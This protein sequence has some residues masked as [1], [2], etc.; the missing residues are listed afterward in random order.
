MSKKIICGIILSILIVIIGLTFGISSIVKFVRM[1]AIIAD[2]KNDV[3]KENYYLKIDATYKGKTSTTET[4]YRDG[5]GKL[6]AENGL[7]TWTDGEKAY[8]VDESL[9]QVEELDYEKDLQLLVTNIRLASLYPTISNNVFERFFIMGNM[10]NK[11]KTIEEDGKEYTYIEIKNKNYIKSYWI[12]K[13][14]N[15]L[16]KSKLELTNGDIYEYKY[17]IKYH[18]T[19]SSDIAL[20]DLK[21]YTPIEHITK[22][23]NENDFKNAGEAEIKN[24]ISK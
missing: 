2:V 7:Y 6:K 4:F 14:T 15:I 8:L 3:L 19:K 5:T 1:Q 23:T 9:K 12:D 10:E 11:I 17:I 20:P 18:S 16:A 22:E 24:E 13:N 21:E